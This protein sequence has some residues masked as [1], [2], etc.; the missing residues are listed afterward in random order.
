MHG[1]IDY[2]KNLIDRDV[3][4]VISVSRRTGGHIPVAEG[5]VHHGQ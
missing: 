2:G 4:V 1:I 5:N 3:T